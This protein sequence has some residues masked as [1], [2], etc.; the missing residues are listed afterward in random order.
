KI[1]FV[2]ASAIFCTVALKAQS[3]SGAVV[4]LEGISFPLRC[5]NSIYVYAAYLGKTLVPYDLAVYYPHPFESLSRTGVGIAAG[6]L[7]AVSIA[8]IVFIRRLP[9]LFVGWFW[10]LGTLVPMIGLVQIGSQQMADRYT[11][12]PLIGVFIALVWVIAN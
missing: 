8:A 3:Q 1:P 6:L 4:A 11:Y 12:F 5:L 10:Y 9:F 7:V 2:A